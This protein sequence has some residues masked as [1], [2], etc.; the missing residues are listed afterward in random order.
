MG[1]LTQKIHY[2]RVKIWVI[3]PQKNPIVFPAT[4]HLYVDIYVCLFLY[5]KFY[6]G[7]I[8]LDQTFD[9]IVMD[10]SVSR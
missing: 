2:L 10:R 5:I 9:R 6:T 7:F 8:I 3:Q 4:I 1:G